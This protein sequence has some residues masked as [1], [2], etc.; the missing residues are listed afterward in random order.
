[1]SGRPSDS[2]N[3]SLRQK[4]RG[5]VQ[6]LRPFFERS[7]RPLAR[8]PTAP[9]SHEFLDSEGA[10]VLLTGRLLEG[11]STAGVVVLH[12]LGG[13][14]ESGYMALALRAAER[15]G[16]TCLL[17]NSRGAD[18]LGADI[19][20]SGLTEDIAEALKSPT[21]DGMTTIDLFGY[22]IGGHIALR[23]ATRDVDA[24]VRRV[25]AIGSPLDLRAAADDF[26]NAPF[27]VYRGHVL[28]A[29]KEI[30]TAAYQRRPSGIEP[31]LARKIQRIRDWDERVV[32]PRFGF[33]S[34]LDYYER[35]SVSTRLSELE[36]QALYVGA[37][38]D[39]MVQRKSVLPFVPAPRLE[40]AW[41][42]HAGHL[43][44]P[45]DFDLGLPG[46]LGVENQ[47]FTWFSEG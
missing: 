46:P 47:V 36:R 34:G 14:A 2:G 3:L 39:P 11:S 33:R 5:H 32:A 45:E 10:P 25:A 7:L 19:Y 12:G 29:L 18:R 1:M 41:D 16:V 8:P 28:D 26:D 38:C 40:V 15:R 21:F 6:T 27:N 4:L 22:S 37:V 44:F 23:Y 17:L 24:R 31:V 35:E 9:W 30:Y 43:G 42:E 13:S 20:H